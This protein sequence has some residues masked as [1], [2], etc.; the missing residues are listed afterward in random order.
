MSFGPW[1]G[2]DYSY[3]LGQIN[4]GT[5]PNMKIEIASCLNIFDYAIYSWWYH[6]PNQ[7]EKYNPKVYMGAVQSVAS[8]WNKDIQNGQNWVEK[9]G[10]C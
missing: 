3:A 6:Y 9:S 7:P 1:T 2:G 8:G 5:N 10:S 4:L